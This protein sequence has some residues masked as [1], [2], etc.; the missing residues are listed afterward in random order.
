LPVGLFERTVNITS[1]EARERVR[2]RLTDLGEPDTGQ[3]PST[4]D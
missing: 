4:G 1:K 3:P 2:R